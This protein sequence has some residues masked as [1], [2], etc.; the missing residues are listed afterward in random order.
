MK[1]FHSWSQQHDHRETNIK[2]HIP[3]NILKISAW[4]LTITDFSFAEKSIHKSSKIVPFMESNKRI[5]FVGVT[6]GTGVLFS[7]TM[8][9]S[10][11]IH[12]KMHIYRQ[13]PETILQ[14]ILKILY[15][16]DTIRV[17]DM[18][19]IWGVPSLLF[20]G[21]FSHWSF[22]DWE[23]LENLSDIMFWVWLGWS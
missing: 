6:E 14:W 12:S 1:I 10:S 5:L 17:G 18:N 4:R 19:I 3:A 20:W 7:V 16:L 21:F 23:W 9:I 22:I 13:E 11:S 8:P 2:I 15:D